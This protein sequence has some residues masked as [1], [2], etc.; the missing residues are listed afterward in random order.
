M[1][2]ITAL[3]S[4]LCLFAG[5]ESN[6]SAKPDHQDSSRQGNI[7]IPVSSNDRVPVIIGL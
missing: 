6:K 5:C 1:K 3:V 2:R 4:L 7:A